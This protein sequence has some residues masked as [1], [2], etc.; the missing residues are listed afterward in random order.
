MYLDNILI[1]SNNPFKYII[2][3]SLLNVRFGSLLGPRGL[4]LIYMWGEN[5]IRENPV[6]RLPAFRTCQ[7]SACLVPTGYLWYSTSLYF[8]YLRNHCC[9]TKP[10]DALVL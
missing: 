8:D 5:S 4:L 2:I 10:T 3:Y 1:Y 6:N 9:R 7:L